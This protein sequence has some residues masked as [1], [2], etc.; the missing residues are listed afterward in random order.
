MPTPSVK[1]A[2]MLA[3]ALTPVLLTGCATT[4]AGGATDAVRASR[5]TTALCEQ[6]APIRWSSRDTDETIAG[7]KRHNAIGAAIC[8]W[9]AG[10]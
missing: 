2:P 10:T 7:A 6:F 3:L 5:A 1:L 8:G 4:T 9:K